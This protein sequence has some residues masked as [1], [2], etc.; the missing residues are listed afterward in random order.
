[1]NPES[2]RQILAYTGDTV[3][4]DA[5]V[6]D[7][8]EQARQALTL[9]AFAC[10]DARESL[11]RSD[12]LDALARLTPVIDE[13]VLPA[14]QAALEDQD[15]LVRTSAIGALGDFGAMDLLWSET[16]VAAVKMFL[17]DRDP[18]VR[19]HAAQTLG[20]LNCQDA[21]PLLEKRL[22]RIRPAN[23]E[24]HYIAFALAQLGVRK[25]WDVFLAGLE[26]E[27]CRCFVANSIRNEIREDE[28]PQ[29]LK[30][31]KKALRVDTSSFTTAAI[32]EAIDGI[33]KDFP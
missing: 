19:I 9:L 28:V 27:P 5:L 2:I 6:S 24:R 13:T 30:A 21:I 20:Q 29:S 12:A 10:T 16:E 15:Y 32:K 31:L 4:T 14:L 23:Y 8:E 25:Y 26:D 17:Q 33:R 7:L 18:L 1:M 11:A 3:V 22:R